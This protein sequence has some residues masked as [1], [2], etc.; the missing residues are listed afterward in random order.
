MFFSSLQAL[1]D[2]PCTHV[3]RKSMNFKELELT[4]LLTKFPHSAKTGVV[5]KAWEKDEISK[6]WEE[7]HLAKKIA[8][9]EKVFVTVQCFVAC[10]KVVQ[11]LAKCQ[12]QLQLDPIIDMPFLE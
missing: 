6:K 1:V 2:G 3:A 7:S 11:L 12:S 8:A 5:K 4:G 10:K 9:K